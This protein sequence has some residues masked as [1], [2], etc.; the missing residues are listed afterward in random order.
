MMSPAR[1]A[2]GCKC[3]SSYANRFGGIVLLVFNA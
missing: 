3:I 1:F 2:S